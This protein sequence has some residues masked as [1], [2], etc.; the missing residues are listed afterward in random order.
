MTEEKKNAA[1]NETQ[2]P[3]QAGEK[4]PAEDIPAENE[5]PDTEKPETEPAEP[6]TEEGADESAAEADPD[7]GTGPKGRRG[8][9]KKLKKEL[10][11]ARKALGEEKKHTA[12]AEERILRIAAEYD[13][14]RKRTQSERAGIYANAVSDTLAGLLPVIDNLQYAAKYSGGDAEKM[15]EGLNMILSKLPETLDKI[16]IKAFGE[17]GDTFDPSLH[18]AVM[19]V[20]D[21]EHGEGEIVEVL[22]QGYMYGDKVPRYA[23]VKSAN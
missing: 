1:E 21:E 10:E 19:H 12:E 5:L 7:A 20:E 6:G 11:E 3:E 15:A 16:G 18:N 14:F 8:E 17:P 22:Q 9:I 13:N 4:R 23:M 2:D